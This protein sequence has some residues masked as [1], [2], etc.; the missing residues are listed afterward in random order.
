MTISVRQ[1]IGIW[2]HFTDEE[3]RRVRDT[4]FLN[5]ENRYFD[6]EDN[7]CPL[8]MA[9]L[10]AS[11]VPEPTEVADWLVSHGRVQPGEYIRTMLDAQDFIKRYDSGDI[12]PI[13]TLPFYIGLTSE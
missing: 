5:S 4:F 9:M 7:W 2:R 10:D 6:G 3:R 12:D 11:T 8:G 1:P 13:D